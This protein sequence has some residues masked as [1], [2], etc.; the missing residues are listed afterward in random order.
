MYGKCNIWR[1]VIK[2]KKMQEVGK[3]EHVEMYVNLKSTRKH[4]GKKKTRA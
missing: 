3:W 4:K 2:A 1:S